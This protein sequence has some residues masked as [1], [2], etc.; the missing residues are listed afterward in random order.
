MSPYWKTLPLPYFYQY[1]TKPSNATNI[2]SV[3]LH[4]NVGTQ[5]SI[6]LIMVNNISHIQTNSPVNTQK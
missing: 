4:E 2:F 1:L 3:S 6:P 5:I